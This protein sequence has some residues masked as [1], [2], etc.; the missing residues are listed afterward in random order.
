MYDKEIIPW[1][2]KVL[3]ADSSGDTRVWV[4]GQRRWVWINGCARTLD[5]SQ[6]VERTVPA[7]DDV[8]AVINELVV[9][10]H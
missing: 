2:K 7:I 6:R 1:V 5:Q 3:L 9:W 10:G 8:K 4:E